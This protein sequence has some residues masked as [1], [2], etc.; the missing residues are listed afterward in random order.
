VFRAGAITYCLFAGKRAAGAVARVLL[1]YLI[2]CGL[3]FTC[4]TLGTLAGRDAALKQTALRLKVEQAKQNKM[5]QWSMAPWDAAIRVSGQ[6]RAYRF[7]EEAERLADKA[8][9]LRNYHTARW[10]QEMNSSAA[11]QRRDE[12]RNLYYVYNAQQYLI[13][14]YAICFGGSWFFFNRLRKKRQW[15][16]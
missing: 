1:A 12:L 4:Y 15:L 8:Y 9:A 10:N 7:D 2:G 13:P 14:Y 3:L 16:E 11:L 6:L 5:R